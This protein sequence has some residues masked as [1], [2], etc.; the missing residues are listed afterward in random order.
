T[1]ALLPA[2]AAEW[3]RVLAPGGIV[4]L[5]VSNGLYRLAVLRRLRAAA[6]SRAAGESLNRRV[7]RATAERAGGLG[8]GVALR[9]MARAGFARPEIYA[10]LPDENQAQVVVPPDDRQV[11][12]Y[13][14]NHLVRQN[15]AL[16]RL[17][18]RA[19]NV[20][21]ALGQFRRVVPYYYLIFRTG[22]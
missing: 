5:G 6:T 2:A 20:V 9:G 17:G 16:V 14:L 19:A 18:V 15:S 10:P 11:V 13:F 22:R 1:A 4:F 7:K 12:R 21:A 8:L 3:R